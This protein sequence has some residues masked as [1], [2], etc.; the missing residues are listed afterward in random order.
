[1][2]NVLRSS[3][4]LRSLKLSDFCFAYPESLEHGPAE[5][6]RLNHL[7]VFNL[8]CLEGN[9]SSLLLSVIVPGPRELSVGLRLGGYESEEDIIYSFLE[10]SLVVTFFLVDRCVDK[11]T[12]PSWLFP[13]LPYMRNFALDCEYSR[14]RIALGAESCPILHTL[15]L[16]GHPSFD[17]LQSHVSHAPKLRIISV[18]NSNYEALT[19]LE[20]EDED[21]EEVTHPFSILAQPLSQ[22]LANLKAEL[23]NALPHLSVDCHDD[24]SLDCAIFSLWPCAN[25]LD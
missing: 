13:V 2:V 5:S 7:E 6:V 1:M 17:G 21:E 18:W 8:S 9:F 24:S 4:C 11:S 20:D 25:D 15:Y 12:L 14:S 22:S 23:E 3:P 19:D 16:I 10:R